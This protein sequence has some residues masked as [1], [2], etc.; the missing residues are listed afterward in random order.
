MGSAIKKIAPIA[1]IAVGAFAGYA[2]FGGALGAI[3][4]ASL[5][6]RLAGALGGG[7]GESGGS[8]AGSVGQS[9][10]PDTGQLATA[11][12]EDAWVPK[13]YGSRRA[14]MVLIA[15]DVMNS[16]H[17]IIETGAS[18]A[19]A[20]S[21]YA[22]GEGPW[23]KINNLNIADIKI[24]KTGQTI[25]FGT[26]YTFGD[27]IFNTDKDFSNLEVTFI[28]GKLGQALPTVL[29]QVT[30]ADGTKWFRDTDVGNGI[31]YMVLRIERK[32]EATIRNTAPTNFT[33]EARGKRVPD[34]RKENSNDKDSN[35]NFINAEYTTNP[36]LIALDQLRTSEF[37]L[38]LTDAEID[39]DSFVDFA[40]YCDTPGSYS[41]GTLIPAFNLNG[42]F[43]QGD[44]LRQILEE[45]SLCTGALFADEN[46]IVTVKIDKFE[47]STTSVAIN[48]DNLV[49]S[50]TRIEPKTSETPNVINVKYIDFDG[51]ET[52]DVVEFSQSTQN[53]EGRK[54]ADLQLRMVASQGQA[55]ELGK[56]YLYQSR[57]PTFQFKMNTA[58]YDLDTYGV[59]SFAD[60][61]SKRALS[62][63]II[64]NSGLNIVS[65]GSKV[66][67]FNI[68]KDRIIESE[69]KAPISVIAKLYTDDIYRVNPSTMVIAPTVKISDAPGLL[70]IP[71]P[72]GAIL[73]RLTDTTAQLNWDNITQ[74]QTTIEFRK[75]STQDFSDAKIVENSPTTIDFLDPATY[76]VRLRYIIPQANVGPGP[77]TILPPFSSTLVAGDGGETSIEN[78][79]EKFSDNNIIQ[80]DP[81]R[82]LN[83]FTHI[84][85][86]D[87]LDGTGLRP[88]ILPSK[89]IESIVHSDQSTTPNSFVFTGTRSKANSTVTFPDNYNAGISA[90]ETQVF[91]FT[92]TRSNVVTPSTNEQLQISVTPD[93]VQNNVFGNS[94]TFELD[95][96]G[97]I[98]FPDANNQSRSY[99]TSSLKSILF[100][101]TNYWQAVDQK[102]RKFTSQSNF[103]NNIFEDMTSGGFDP[104][105]DATTKH[106]GG[107][108]YTAQTRFLTDGAGIQLLEQSGQPDNKIIAF[109]VNSSSSRTNTSPEYFGT[110]DVT[111]NMWSTPVEIATSLRSPVHLATNGSNTV[112]INGYT[113]T[114]RGV[115]FSESNLRDSDSVTATAGTSDSILEVPSLYYFNNRFIAFRRNPNTSNNAGSATLSR[116]YRNNRLIRSSTNGTSWSD[117]LI[118]NDGDSGFTFIEAGNRLFLVTDEGSLSTSAR[119]GVRTTTNGTA[120]SRC[121]FDVEASSQISRTPSLYFYEGEFYF[122]VRANLDGQTPV[123]KYKSIEGL[124]FESIEESDDPTNILQKV[125]YQIQLGDS[126]DDYYFGQ[127][128]L[129][130]QGT[131]GLGQLQLL[132]EVD[133]LGPIITKIN[134]DDNSPSTFT[135][136]GPFPLPYTNSVNLL[137]DIQT[138]ALNNNSTFTSPAITN[139]EV[140][141]TPG[142]FLNNI[143]NTTDYTASIKQNSLALN[144]ND[145]WLPQSNSTPTGNISKSTNISA[146]SPTYTDV[147]AG[148]ADS[149]NNFYNQIAVYADNNILASMALVDNITTFTPNSNLTDESN[150]FA[151]NISLDNGT[152]FGER[153]LGIIGGDNDTYAL[154][155][156]TAISTTSLSPKGIASLSN[157]QQQVV[158]NNPD[159]NQ[160]RFSLSRGLKSTSDWEYTGNKG[161]VNTITVPGYTFQQ[162]GGNCFYAEGIQYDSSEI[163]NCDVFNYDTG[164][165][166]TGIGFGFIDDCPNSD[167]QTFIQSLVDGQPLTIQQGDLSYTG[168]VTAIS[169]G[170]PAFVLTGTTDIPTG[171]DQYGEF[172]TADRVVS[173]GSDLDFINLKSNNDDSL[174][175]LGRENG[176]NENYLLSSTNVNESIPLTIT[177]FPNEAARTSA[178]FSDAL[179]PT[180]VIGDFVSETKHNQL[181]NT[182]CTVNSVTE[183]LIS[184][185]RNGSDY[186]FGRK[187]INIANSATGDNGRVRLGARAGNPDLVTT[188]SAEGDMDF[189]AA[190]FKQGDTIF[191]DDVVQITST[192]PDHD[193]ITTNT[194]T[195]NTTGPGNSSITS[196]NSGDTD[197]FAVGDEIQVRQA[198][199]TQS[200]TG[201]IDSISGTTY[202]MSERNQNITNG[203][204]VTAG[205]IILRIAGTNG[206][207]FDNFTIG[208]PLFKREMPGY[209]WN[210]ISTTDVIQK[211]TATVNTD[212][213]L[214]YLDE[215][216][217]Y[218]IY[219]TILLPVANPTTPSNVEITKIARD[220]T[221]SFFDG[222]V[223][224]EHFGPAIYVQ[225]DD[226]DGDGAKFPDGSVMTI[227][228]SDGITDL[229]VIVDN[230][231]D[232]DDSYDSAFIFRPTDSSIT[233]IPAAFTVSAPGNA[234]TVS[235]LSQAVEKQIFYTST[236]GTTWA[237][238]G[239]ATDSDLFNEL[240]DG[241]NTLRPVFVNNKYLVKG[242]ESTDLIDWTATDLH[243]IENGTAIADTDLINYNGSLSDGTIF[244]NSGNIPFI[245]R[246]TANLLTLTIDYNTTSDHTASLQLES[247]GVP[248]TLIINDINGQGAGIGPTVYTVTSPD[249]NIGTLT[250]FT[251]SVSS[252]NSSDL[253]SVLNN[254]R[255]AINGVNEPS[256]TASINI[257]AKTITITADSS[258]TNSGTKRW[259][260]VAT[261]DPANNL[262]G[263]IVFTAGT[264]SGAVTNKHFNFTVDT[265]NSHELKQYIGLAGITFPS[266]AN[267]T[268]SAAYL[269]SQIENAGM[270]NNNIST[271]TTTN[272]NND[273]IVTFDFNVDD[274]I[275]QN[276]TFF[277]ADTT[278]DTDVTDVNIDGSI[279]NIFESDGTTSISS[280]SAFRAAKSQLILNEPDSNVGTFIINKGYFNAF[281][282]NTL[283]T[284]VSINGNNNSTMGNVTG[285]I[286]SNIIRQVHDAIEDTNRWNATDITN[287]LTVDAIQNLKYNELWNWT[288][289]NKGRNG[290]IETITHSTDT[291]AIPGVFIQ[292]TAGANVPSFYGL[293]STE[294]AGQISEE[295]GD[296]CWFTLTNNQA[297]GIALIPSYQIITPF[298]PEFD[299]D[300][301]NPPTNL[302]IP[303]G[304]VSFNTNIINSRQ[305]TSTQINNI[306]VISP[307]GTPA[308]GS[309]TTFVNGRFFIAV[310]VNKAE[311]FYQYTNPRVSTTFNSNSFLGAKIKATTDGGTP[312]FGTTI[313]NTVPFKSATTGDKDTISIISRTQ[314]GVGNQGDFTVSESSNDVSS[315]NLTAL[316]FL[317]VNDGDTIEIND[318]SY[319]VSN[320]TS[321]NSRSGN[322]TRISLG[323]SGTFRTDSD[324][325]NGIITGN[326]NINLVSGTAETFPETGTVEIG[327]FDEEFSYIKSNFGRIQTYSLTGGST[328]SQ[329]GQQA[330]EVVITAT[331]NIDTFSTE[332]EYSINNEVQG[333]SRIFK[334]LTDNNLNNALPT[335]D[336]DN[337]DWEFVRNLISTIVLD[338]SIGDDTDLT[339]GQIA[340]AISASPYIIDAAGDS[341]AGQWANGTLAIRFTQLAGDASV[342]SFTGTQSGMSLTLLSTTEA[343][344]V[345]QNLT[346][347][348]N[349]SWLADRNITTDSTTPSLDL[350]STPSTAG[351]GRDLSLAKPTFPNSGTTI[352]PSFL[353]NQVYRWTDDGLGGEWVQIS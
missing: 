20:T 78:G 81:V 252:N 112:V 145:Y 221:E 73:T 282:D 255:D 254:I 90:N 328:T 180:F 339:T 131:F 240:F 119:H 249:I 92:G 234:F 210:R 265:S 120:W 130:G 194:L 266:G 236:N 152:S 330:G 107:T 243:L 51:F 46:G 241:K 281:T 132:D 226:F 183:S 109:L 214:D 257:P 80:T 353:P 102:L 278:E 127:T 218:S 318:I 352:N 114:D 79:V 182:G 212:A 143:L 351:N 202:T 69:G 43:G 96:N 5:G 149:T 209:H 314:T 140:T 171:F 13:Q 118:V 227:R 322:N 232:D 173:V 192:P 184:F 193:P 175:Y 136:I 76:V 61:L 279:G 329:I 327:G 16:S 31:C 50:I 83:D 84:R 163:N 117:D 223:S 168:T 287:K 196:S 199:G 337:S 285:S 215:E 216:F 26:T 128:G 247:N 289:D 63:S 186:S 58:G 82:V 316:S 306:P 42:Q 17:Q 170:Y 258:L 32:K 176:I 164:D 310:P 161:T 189:L 165:C 273:V 22:L 33:I 85:Y 4:G 106:V 244:A 239:V 125:S 313:L 10:I 30:N 153:K 100:D 303:T 292:T 286:S 319:I 233:T 198:S 7:S 263:D 312:E 297:T 242:A 49:E 187:M 293:R 188:I 157:T 18:G 135:P 280:P 34:I 15:S 11:I 260:I 256:F 203:T 291:P 68:T 59:C 113:S 272:L 142:Q 144:G 217:V 23:D 206:H 197:L 299:W 115:T 317:K 137:T 315:V 191:I 121:T 229:E 74:Y 344:D 21:V 104:R 309:V 155:Q 350:V 110:Y 335:T 347:P 225:D 238:K 156:G 19:F 27:S 47:L 274:T 338:G 308:E 29:S 346:I 103:D 271:S 321:G 62:G 208:A 248:G 264:F 231:G 295:I 101:G 123:A 336:V 333:N 48:E 124:V 116:I 207:D 220:S 169:P 40:N 342:T 178:V 277:N 177:S 259:S 200:Y 6:F 36:A 8:S 166:F 269:I 139:T 253:T 89:E 224:N 38:G 45:I 340:N 151:L 267:A 129:P 261:N 343:D 154:D 133:N 72:T 53:A 284:P 134:F 323:A 296:Y 172:K 288:I 77:F 86:A 122:I 28:Q 179:A 75:S 201:T 55:V 300:G 44:T 320:K 105:T 111:T 88:N 325:T 307:D 334:S 24:F 146:P 298:Q 71:A 56:R 262:P 159:G 95:T 181:A 251:S 204:I 1:V 228:A 35:G 235:E 301:T 148:Q 275:G 237:V 94:K 87:K 9:N 174:V 54:E 2:V 39:F 250:T 311:D 99:N 65:T 276:F 305:T 246:S 302:T 283:T 37:G 91:D 64:P 3:R 331:S 97:P 41:D 195:Y 138:R 108:N 268:Q 14:G 66:R 185:N 167:N 162:A 126:I 304:Y 219:G 25:D 160:T 341:V 57:Q 213:K 93:F 205:F 150:Q 348:T 211:G 345:L 222:G 98:I 70:N 349:E 294:I 324:N 326:K 52:I 158:A 147:R 141:A 290:T 67:I 230:G 12:G 332:I 270:D 60:P 245:S 190:G